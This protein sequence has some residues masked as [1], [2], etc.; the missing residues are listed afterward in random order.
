MVRRRIVTGNLHVPL[1]V[2]SHRC[3]YTRE[4]S[5]E[6]V[7]AITETLEVS[8]DQTDVRNLASQ[9]RAFRICVLEEMKVK[10]RL[11]M[12]AA[13]NAASSNTGLH[14]MSDFE[15]EVVQRNRHSRNSYMIPTAFAKWVAGEI[16]VEAKQQEY[17][18]KLS[19]ALKGVVT[20]S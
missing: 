2:R 6:V 16:G 3:N 5:W 4:L 15:K 13:K 20:K 18:L 10:R 8:F 14:I 17:A 12:E 19:N 9:E 7:R 1:R 11:E